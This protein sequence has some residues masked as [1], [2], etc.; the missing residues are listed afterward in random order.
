MAAPGLSVSENLQ[1]RGTPLLAIGE[2]RIMAK[3]ICPW[4]LGYF[5]MNPVRRWRQNP[6][7]I[8]RPFVS[9]GMLVV[10]P[11]CGM[12]FFTLELAR[13]VG[14]RGRIIAVD[15]QE[16]MLAGLRR[17]AGKAGFAGRIE[18]RLATPGSLMLD[19]LAGRADFALAI[20]VVHELPD[21]DYFFAVMHRA[22]RSGSKL[23]VAEPRAHVKAAEFQASMDTARRSGFLISDEPVIRASRSAVLVS[24]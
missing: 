1:G 6:A 11:G 19:D 5:L 15:I 12:G 8:L 24:V 14:P 16:R 22:L 13:L 2:R 18:A 9:E 4:W 20:A 23:L 17:R 10:E 7:K 21:Q 3:R